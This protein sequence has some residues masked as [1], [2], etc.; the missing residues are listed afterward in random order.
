MASRNQTVLIVVAMLGL[1]SAAQGGGADPLRCEA[2]QL[3]AE[4]QYFQ[5]VSRCDRRAARRPP[6]ARPAASGADCEDKCAA[7]HDE[8][9]QRIALTAPCA[10]AEGAPDPA[11]CEA[12]LLRIAANDRVCTSRCS[13]RERPSETVADCE[14]RCTTRC[15][16]AVDETLARAIC[17]GGRMSEDQVCGDE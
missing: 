15:A 3:R 4:S 9:M 14:A 17:T 7:R 1:A 8:T 11:S 6:G 16:T 12:R 5:C 2:R 13:R 10:G